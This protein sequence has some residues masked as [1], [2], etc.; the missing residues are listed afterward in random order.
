MRKAEKFIRLRRKSFRPHIK[1]NLLIS[2][3]FFGLLKIQD[4][5]F[6]GDPHATWHP[7]HSGLK[8]S[9]GHFLYVPSC[10]D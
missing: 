10:P 6:A 2:R 7:E 8:M 3:G 4:M 1:R 5:I 9:I